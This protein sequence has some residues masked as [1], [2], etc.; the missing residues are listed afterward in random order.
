MAKAFHP[1]GRSRRGLAL[2]ATALLLAGIASAPARAQEESI[3]RPLHYAVPV[4]LIVVQ[5]SKRRLLLYYRDRVVRRFRIALGRAPV[6]HKHRRGD[7]RT[8]EGLYYVDLKRAESAFGEA[9]KI[10]YPNRRDRA[11]ASTHGIDPG[12]EIYIHGRP[13]EA[14]RYAYFRS[15][16]ANTDWT[17]GCIALDN[18]AMGEI[19]RSV[20]AGTPVLIRP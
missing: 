8:P 11:A 4:D 16:F 3:P 13:R 1:A 17:D 19:F 7:G 20:H 14:M 18:E 15:K 12:G 6:G 9:L 2:A 5:K 10:D